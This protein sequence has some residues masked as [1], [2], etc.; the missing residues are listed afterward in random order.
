MDVVITVEKMHATNVFFGSAKHALASLLIKSGSQYIRLI[1]DCKKHRPYAVLIMHCVDCI[2][3][4]WF[5]VARQV[6]FSL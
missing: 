5:S 2:A 1:V 3:E 4:E 6:I